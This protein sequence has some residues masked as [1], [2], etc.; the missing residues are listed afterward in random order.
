MMVMNTPGG[1]TVSTAQLAM[2][3]LCSLAR[4]IPAAD[5]SVKEVSNFFSQMSV[6]LVSHLCVVWYEYVIIG[7]VGRYITNVACFIEPTLHSTFNHPPPNFNPN[8]S[9]GKWDRKSFT[10][11][12]MS[13]KT[14]GIIGCGRIGQE[15][16]NCAREMGMVV[17]GRC[18][19]RI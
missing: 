1:N 9:Q 12:E 16:A 13:G 5:M 8:L 18:L 19:F 3:L 15:V 6:C 7:F 14:L 17:K 10:G 2:S 4:N 11:I